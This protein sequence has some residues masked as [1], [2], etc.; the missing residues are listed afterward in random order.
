L[1]FVG[2]DAVMLA[3]SPNRPDQ[4]SRLLYARSFTDT[5][6]WRFETGAAGEP[7]TSAPTMAV[8]TTRWDAQPNVSPDGRRLVFSS[9]R[10][11]ENEIWVSDLDGANAA[12]LTAQRANP[13][14]P[15]WSPDGSLIAYHSDAENTAGDIFVVP[16]A[17]GKPRRLTDDIGP[18]TFPAFSRDGQSIYFASNRS[19]S[20]S[21][22][23]MPVAG[24]TPVQI[25]KRP[26]IHA[27]ESM[28]G[29]ALFFVEGAT[30]NAGGPLLRMPLDGGQVTKIVDAADPLRFD[31]RAE[32]IYYVM[33]VR[34]ESTLR[35]VNL[36]TGRDSLIGSKLGRLDYGLSSTPDGRSIFFSR[37][38]SSVD[39]LMLV[40]RFR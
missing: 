30:M 10:S 31:V 14:F 34:G 25:I 38:D 26:T 2:G 39:D 8:S 17:G 36:I 33:M 13:G 21:I 35:Y 24:G 23:K 6:I 22:W 27:Q 5:N 7:V 20:V 32:G 15:R 11:G 1:P 18:D 37:I 19:G 28:D 12:P 40:E 4:F 16:S 9:T 29:S 3:I